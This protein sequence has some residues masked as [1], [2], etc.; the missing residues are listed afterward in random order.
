MDNIPSE[1]SDSLEI[2][3]EISRSDSDSDNNEPDLSD[4]GG[5]CPRFEKC[6]DAM[7]LR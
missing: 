4:T 2:H 6:M 5:N 1:S 3:V 7:V